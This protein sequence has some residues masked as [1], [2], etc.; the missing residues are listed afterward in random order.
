MPLPDPPE[1]VALQREIPSVTFAPP[2]DLPPGMPSRPTSK[3]KFGFQ[4]NTQAKPAAQARASP[5][6]ISVSPIPPP[7]VEEENKLPVRSDS[8]IEEVWSRA[9]IMI[10]SE[11]IEESIESLK[12]IC[13]EL[14]KAK[15]GGTPGTVLLLK[16]S[17][18]ELVKELIV[19]LQ[20]VNPLSSPP[21]IQ[22]LEF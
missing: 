4:V 2:I 7:A 11:D 5:V 22:D 20:K 18:S 6:E 14:D 19:R 8:V 15:A 17:A 10:Q 3:L 21:Y 13:Y 9:M 12:I 16:D 1:A